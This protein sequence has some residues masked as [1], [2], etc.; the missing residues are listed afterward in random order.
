MKFYVVF[1][2]N[3]IVSSLLSKNLESPTVRV[4]DMISEG[5]IIPVFSQEILDEY[6][7]VLL[8][9]KFP[10]SVQT[11]ER[12]MKIFL[13][14]GQKIEPAE[15]DEPFLRDSD[16]RVFYEV[17]MAKRNDVAENESAYL[18]SGNL[19]H[20]PIKTFIVTPAEMLDI[21]NKRLA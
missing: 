6:T 16:D 8:R 9:P 12:L 3:V 17:V 1:D 14:F 5:Q 2:T 21:I 19:K 20:Y 4:V 15:T 11:V 13:Q 7:D 18:V 10:F